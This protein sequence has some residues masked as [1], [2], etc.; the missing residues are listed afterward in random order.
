MKIFAKAILD[1]EQIEARKSLPVNGIEILLNPKNL[2][3]SNLDDKLKLC[4][5]NF[6]TVNLE[7]GDRL[8]STVPV[9][10]LDPESRKYIEKVLELHSQIPNPGLVVAHLVG[11]CQVSDPPYKGLKPQS[12][13]QILAASLE[14]IRKLDPENKIIALENTFPTD[15]MDE[16][17]GIISFYPIGKISSGFGNRIRTFDIAHSGITMYTYKN[18]VNSYFPSKQFG[19]IPVYFSDEEQK[20]SELAKQSLTD[21]VCEELRKAN[22]VNVH[23]NVN[24]GLLDGFVESSDLDLSKVLEALKGKDITLVAEVQ[25]RE[26]GDY[27]STPNQ[28]AMVDYLRNFF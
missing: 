17:E 19:N 10:L 22:T 2:S 9:D 15:W 27:I 3:E 24:K 18:L 14:Y 1:S 20:V 12:K 13:P 26:T 8:Y 7:V 4:S 25:E 23:V 6:E 21:A 11:R 5:D 16:N 28:R